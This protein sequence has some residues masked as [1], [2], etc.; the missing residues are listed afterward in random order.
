MRQYEEKL[1]AAQAKGML[2]EFPED[3]KEFDLIARYGFLFHWTKDEETGLA[4]IHT[5]GVEAIFGSPELRLVIP[6]P[7]E[8]ASAVLNL[9]VDQ[10]RAGKALEP[11]RVDGLLRDNMPMLLVEDAGQYCDRILRV[12]LPDPHG[13]IDE[14]TM[15][16]A[17]AVQFEGLPGRDPASSPDDGPALH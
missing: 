17:Y 3:S 5:H 12:V 14:K 7:M 2:L 8:T 1:L 13:S 10:C 9:L 11:G 6:V 15:A 16:P 4:D